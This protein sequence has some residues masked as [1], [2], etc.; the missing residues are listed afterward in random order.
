MLPFCQRPLAREVGCSP[1]YSETGALTSTICELEDSLETMCS[2]P[3]VPADRVAAVM[4]KL[5][6]A[7]LA[8]NADQGASGEA[9]GAEATIEECVADF[10]ERFPY[11]RFDEQDLMSLVRE[12]VLNDVHEDCRGQPV[13][14]RA[15]LE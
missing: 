4:S 11:V 3:L 13:P 12:A 14:K 7:K 10:F 9:N 5:V 6:S 8:D 1:F 15:R 2:D